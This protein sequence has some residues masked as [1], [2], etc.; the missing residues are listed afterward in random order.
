MKIYR[1]RICDPTKDEETSRSQSQNLNSFILRSTVF[2][3]YL[4]PWSKSPPSVLNQGTKCYSSMCTC[5]FMRLWDGFVKPR[6][7]NISISFVS[8]ILI[9]G[10]MYED[11]LETIWSTQSPFSE[12]YLLTLGYFLLFSQFH[13]WSTTSASAGKMGN[14]NLK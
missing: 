5:G 9:L 3:L 1:W 2:L 10:Y 7:C 13:T 8:T 14:R 6:D 11:N 4:A 12:N